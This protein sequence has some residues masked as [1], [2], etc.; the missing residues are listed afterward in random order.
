MTQTRILD[1]AG[2]QGLL[3]VPLDLR[4]RSTAESN[5]ALTIDT[6]INC[7][8]TKTLVSGSW[9]PYSYLPREMLLCKDRPRHATTKI[10]RKEQD[11]LCQ[12]EELKRDRSRGRPYEKVRDRRARD[13]RSMSAGFDVRSRGVARCVQRY[14]NVESMSL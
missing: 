10:P 1:I 8:V 14:E 9:Y 3:V 12:G 4:E 6:R 13:G 5:A 2:N 11:N 7:V